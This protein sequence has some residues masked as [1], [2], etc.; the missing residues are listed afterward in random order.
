MHFAVWTVNDVQ[1]TLEKIVSSES[2]QVDSTDQKKKGPMRFFLRFSFQHHWEFTWYFLKFR[3]KK[4]VKVQIFLDGHNNFSLLPVFIW[5]YLV[6]SNHKW[7]MGQIFWA[8][9]EYPNFSCYT[10]RSCLLPLAHPFNLNG[11]SRLEFWDV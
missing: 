9:S 10:L 8:F 2:F 4:I 6:A 3:N 1:R 7:K 5:H 11:E